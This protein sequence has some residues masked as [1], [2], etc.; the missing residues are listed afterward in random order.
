MR[1]RTVLPRNLLAHA[2]QHKGDDD[3]DNDDKNN[4]H[5]G[6]G[7]VCGTPPDGSHP[8]FFP[9]FLF[10][11]YFFAR[12]CYQREAPPF[13]LSGARG[14]WL[15]CA[16]LSCRHP[17]QTA[18]TPLL[19]TRPSLQQTA[20]ALAQSARRKPN[21]LPPF[22]GH[23][24]MGLTFLGQTFFCCCCCCCLDPKKPQELV[25]QQDGAEKGHRYLA[26]PWS[27]TDQSKKSILLNAKKRKRQ[28]SLAR[29]RNV[30]IV[31]LGI[32]QN[33]RR[34]ASAHKGEASFTT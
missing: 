1:R 23:A 33:V 31:F 28:R 24:K 13:A 27:R 19:W 2:G 12:L 17:R 6:T 22:F 11:W 34:R 30:G 14:G 21:S 18:A 26:V 16:P 5:D 3:K 25:S 7:C 4:H 9:L 15:P 32:G 10:S 20:G 29:A 8:L